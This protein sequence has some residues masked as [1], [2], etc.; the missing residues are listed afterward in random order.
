MSSSNFAAYSDESGING[1]RYTSI[2]IVSGRQDTLE[3]LRKELTGI[4]SNKNR[5]ID[6]VKFS[7]IRGF[8]SPIYQA[9]KQFIFCAVNK[10]A[11][12]RNII[13]IDTLTWDRQGSCHS[14]VHRNEKPNLEHLYCQ[15]LLHIARQWDQTQWNF[16][17]DTSSKINWS[18]IILSLNMTRLHRVKAR[19]PLLINFLLEENLNF[20]FSEVKQ[21]ASIEEPLIQLA[22]LFAGMARFSSEE[23]VK[24]AKW[25]ISQTDSKQQHKFKFGLASDDYLIKGTK[26]CRYQLIG[27]LYHICGKHRL[28]VSLKTKQHLW[29]RHP[30]YPVNFWDYEEKRIKPT[31]V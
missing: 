21:V 1:H 22:D 2:T 25:A 28:F 12:L 24:C 30:S 5:P 14:T 27:E 19:K 20:Q 26:Q 11:C 23:N 17:P 16:Y 7:K 10:F 9:A 8:E 4:L 6:E 31:Q 15:L 3:N 18:D 29:T 13:R